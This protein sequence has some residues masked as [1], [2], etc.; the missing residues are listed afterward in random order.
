MP[1]PEPVM[2]RV[3]GPHDPAWPALIALY[4]R[5]FEEG[6]RETERAIVRNLVTSQNRR[7]G[8][9]IVY[10]AEQRGACVGGNIF[11]YLPAID[12][13]YVSYIFVDPASRSRGIGR[14]LLRAMRTCLANEAADAGRPDVQGLFA[15]IERGED[16]GQSLQRRFRFWEQAGV[17]PLD[18]AWRYPPLHDGDPPAPM[19]LAFGSYAPAAPQWYPGGLARVARAIFDATYSYLPSANA[20]LLSIREELDRLPQDQPVP[21]IRP[22]E[23]AHTPRR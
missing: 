10:V 4:T 13:G 8:G 22:W 9:H 21:Y 7:H 11:S 3:S 16:A 17:L 20:T 12:A 23:A 6:Q 2:R 14:A 18:L 5:I 15:E 1:S 19:Y